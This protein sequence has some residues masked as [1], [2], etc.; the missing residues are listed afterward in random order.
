[1]KQFIRLTLQTFALV[2][3]ILF[4][5]PAI[6]NRSLDTTNALVL[7][8]LLVCVLLQSIHLLLHKIPWKSRV[9]EIAVGLG[10]VQT[11]VLICG[12]LFSWYPQS[13]TWFL[14]VIAT[15]VYGIYYWLNYCEVKKEIERINQS[16]C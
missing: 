7:E 15:I 12:K 1:M 4:T 13:S 10:L 5:L 16:L 2:I 14:C 8:V 6:I 11:I 9:V 3:L